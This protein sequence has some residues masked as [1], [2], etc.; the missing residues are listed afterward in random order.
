VLELNVRNLL[1]SR[2]KMRQKF[3]RQLQAREPAEPALSL[4]NSLDSAFLEKLA[5]LVDEHMDDPEFGVD[6]LARKVAMSQPVLYRKL[7]ALTNMSVNDFVK[8]L[9][10][11][12]AAELIRKKQHT[13][14][15]VAYMVGYNDRKYFSRE[16]KKQF[17]KTPTEFASEPEL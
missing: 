14:Y 11:K 1:V 16:F 8:S 13:V 7:K 12:K 6:M 10:L 5:Q 4:P 2:E 15:E 3:G 9:R 17:G